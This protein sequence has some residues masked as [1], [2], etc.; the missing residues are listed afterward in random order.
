MAK[1]QTQ[2]RKFKSKAINPSPSTRSLDALSV[3]VHGVQ[4]MSKRFEHNLETQT[5]LLACRSSAEVL[6]VQSDYVQTAMK[7]YAAAGQAMTLLL[8][9]TMRDGLHLAS[10]DYDDVPL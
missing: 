7:H 9:T 6:A 5:K 10:R 1:Q 2:S 4:F 8:S 3:F